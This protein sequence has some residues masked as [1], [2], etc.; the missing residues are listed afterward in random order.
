[1]LFVAMEECPGHFGHIELAKRV[2]H[3]G[4]LTYL[5]KILKTICFNCSRLL[6]ARDKDSNEYKFLV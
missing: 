1:M 2:Y 6:I 4:L 5:Q 3:A